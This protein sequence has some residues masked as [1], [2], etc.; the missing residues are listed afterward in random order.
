MKAQAQSD[1]EVLNQLLLNIATILGYE[2][3]VLCRSVQ[4]IT[5]IWNI[6]KFILYTLEDWS[7]PAIAMRFDLSRG[8]GMTISLKKVMNA[9]E[10]KDPKLYPDLLKINKVYPILSLGVMKYK[11]KQEEEQ[12]RR[13]KFGTS[14]RALKRENNGGSINIVS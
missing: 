4:Q 9:I 5:W 11:L 1:E 8:G 6:A 12:R 10:M 7:Q 14:K 3:P 13:Q 2:D